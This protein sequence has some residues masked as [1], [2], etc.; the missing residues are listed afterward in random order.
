MINAVYVADDNSIEF[1]SNPFEFFPFCV[2]LVKFSSNA[3][4]FAP[5]GTRSLLRGR[6]VM[7]LI[8][9]SV[10]AIGWSS[11]ILPSWYQLT[12]N[13]TDSYLKVP[14][15]STMGAFRYD[16]I[17][18]GVTFLAF[19]LFAQSLISTQCLG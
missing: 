3:G 18:A 16:L 19:S 9:L 2:N 4:F 8:N 12:M 10:I 1:I 17:L 6:L 14:K 15:L 5:V 13:L 11:H 7:K